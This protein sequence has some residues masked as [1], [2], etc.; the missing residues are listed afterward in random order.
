MAPGIYVVM[1]KLPLSANGKVDRKALPPPLSVRP[2][3]ERAFVPAS[4]ETERIIAQIWREALKIDRV[5]IIDNFFDIGGHSLLMV[6]VHL[7][8]REKFQ[9]E[10]S[11]IDLFKYPTISAL[12]E[13]IE[14]GEQEQLATEGVSAQ[15][16]RLKQGKNR[17]QH[18]YKL[19]K[20]SRIQGEG[21]DE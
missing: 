5:G 17:L 7:L 11:I 9:S 20:Q 18:Q 12:A 15:S 21:N 4:T 6:Q 8:L 19:R 3:T 16:E 1:E 13:F 10:I 2:H 14:K